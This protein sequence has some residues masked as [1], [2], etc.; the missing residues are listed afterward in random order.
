[1]CLFVWE[2]ILKKINLKTMILQCDNI[3]KTYKNKTG[4]TT[5][6][7]IDLSFSVD[8]SDFVSI[9]GASGSGKSTLLHIFGGLDM[10]DKGDVI[11]QTDKSTNIYKL[12]DK[13]LSEI[14]NKYFGFIFQFH[15]LLPEFSALE[16]VAMPSL[17][18]GKSKNE[19][20]DKAK[21]LLDK[22]GMTNFLNKKPATLS[23]GEQ[24]RVAIARALINEPLI[25]FADEPTGNL[26]SK[27]SQQFLEIIENLISELKTTF[28]IATHSQ[29]I[30]DRAAKKYELV[31]GKLSLI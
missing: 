12:N 14:R 4:T 31:A 2:E 29:E 25:V 20:Y 9:Q 6:V 24:Q 19:S 8:K 21:L 27:N 22:V 30:A 18:A 28:I 7:L 16:N 17:I 10:P 11:L 15:H 3:Y 23:G 26:D 1:M 5:E 13:N